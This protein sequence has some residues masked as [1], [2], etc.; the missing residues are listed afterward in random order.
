MPRLT[1]LEAINKACGIIERAD[2]RLLAMDGP[3]GNSAPDMTLA[4]WRELYV[5]LDNARKPS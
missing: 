3:C 5:T 2:A 4:E 1:R